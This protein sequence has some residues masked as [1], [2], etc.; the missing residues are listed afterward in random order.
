MTTP[1]YLLAVVPLAS[2]LFALLVGAVFLAATGHPPIRT[3]LDLLDNGYT[4]FYGITDTLGLATPLVCTGLA[5]AFAFHRQHALAQ[6][7]RAEPR[8]LLHLRIDWLLP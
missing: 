7:R 6:L 3:Y 4:S 1:S 2:V 8:Q 5:A